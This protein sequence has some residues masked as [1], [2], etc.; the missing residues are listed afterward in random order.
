MKVVLLKDVEKLGKKYEVKEVKPGYAR[1]FLLPQGLAKQ[2][3]KSVLK[4]LEM[5]KDIEAKKEEDE[6]KQVQQLASG[7]EG[8]EVAIPVKIG[9]NG[10]MF[11]SITLQKIS[12]KLKELG[13]NIKKNQ[14]ILASPIKELGEFPIKIKF[15]HNLEAEIKIIVV[16][17]K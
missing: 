8:Q 9:E 12:E 7:I 17:E 10:E 15:N 13:F 6:L 14:I 1:N 5:Q 3:T 4:W 2:A 11:E 16:E